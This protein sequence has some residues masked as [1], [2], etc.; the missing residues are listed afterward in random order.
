MS[1][2]VSII[3]IAYNQEK[4]I[5]QTL[6]GFVS[7][8][9]DFPF[10]VLIHDDASTDSTAKIIQ[11]YAKKYPS[12]IKPVFEEKNQYTLTT[13][14]FLND[15]FY[16]AK[17]K[18]IALCEGDDFWTDSGKLQKQVDFL[19]AHPDYSVCFHPVNIHYDNGGEKDRISP[20][21][22]GRKIF[23]I[24]ALLKDNYI[25]TCSVM[26]RKQA[27]KD[28]PDGIMPHDV[29]MHLLH[30]KEGKIG[31]INQVMGTYR[32]Q[33]GGVWWE[34]G[35]HMKRIYEKHRYTLTNLFAEVL[36]MFDSTPRY[37]NALYKHIDYLFDSFIA[38]DKT[39][40]T[41]LFIETARDF[42]EL[43]AGYTLRKY[44]LLNEMDIERQRL[45]GLSNN[46]ADELQSIKDSKWYRLNPRVIA[47]RHEHEPDAQ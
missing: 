9:T 36:K 14:K 35:A 46:Q 29:Y 7:Q 42:P 19:E 3:C 45:Q 34:S 33:D 2:L 24:E 16:S 37:K 6:D 26:Y 27:Y 10:E 1:P 44:E 23:T 30:A 38:I 43:V 41:N 20:L 40:K 5:K 4:F 25:H 12:I 22:D 15:L 47:Q 8:E 11:E 21:V 39:R 32:K 13:W 31:F 18:Y 28:L 17:G